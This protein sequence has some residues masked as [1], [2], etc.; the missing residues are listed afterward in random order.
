ML[1][2]TYIS[3][4]HYSRSKLFVLQVQLQVSLWKQSLYW[5][6]RTEIS[7]LKKTA[8]YIFLSFLRMNLVPVL[9]DFFPWNRF[10]GPT[11]PSR[12]DG[13]LLRRLVRVLQRIRGET[14]LLTVSL[15][16]TRI[17][18]PRHT[19]GEH[20]ARPPPPLGPRSQ[21]QSIRWWTLMK[22][23]FW[24]LKMRHC[25]TS[26]AKTNQLSCILYTHQS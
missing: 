21:S 7:Q 8:P 14:P 25:G 5:I 22:M 26:G 11:G 1:L 23:Q 15:D 24:Q 13:Q 12:S 19:E 3:V 20:V 2:M 6:I 16:A 17:A 9:S 10:S 4:N 18:D